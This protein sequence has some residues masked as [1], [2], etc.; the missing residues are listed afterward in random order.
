MSTRLYPGWVFSGVKNEQLEQHRELL[1]SLLDAPPYDGGSGAMLWS[2]LGNAL[3]LF[4][5][6]KELE[7]VF[8]QPTEVPL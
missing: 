2:V 6:F 5:L 4:D 7:L 8:Y 3:D 1:R